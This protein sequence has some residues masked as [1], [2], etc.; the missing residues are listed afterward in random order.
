MQAAYWL[1]SNSSLY[2]DVGI[3][4][5]P[6]W[7]NQYNEE[8]SSHEDESNDIPDEQSVIV[9]ENRDNVE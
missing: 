2:R 7:S 8:I 3:V 4:V 6:E 9:N 5:N 1:M